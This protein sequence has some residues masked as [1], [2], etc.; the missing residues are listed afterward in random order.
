MLPA[1]IFQFHKGTS[2]TVKPIHRAKFLLYFNSIKVQVK[3][4]THPNYVEYPGFQFHKGTS[5]T[6]EA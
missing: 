5:K 3:Q 4:S 1:I 2:K 6:G